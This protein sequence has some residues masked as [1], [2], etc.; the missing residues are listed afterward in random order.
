MFDFFFD[1]ADIDYIKTLWPKMPE[2]FSHDNIRGI[3]TNPNA[4]DKL[5]MTTLES[6]K[7]HLPKLCSLVSE[8]RGDNLGVV[9]VQMPS[10]SMS[11]SEAV[12]W[13]KYISTYSD[14]NT[15]LGLK[16][17]P[18]YNILSGAD[19][20]SEI[21]DLNVTGVSDCSTALSCF[22]FN[23]RYV[24]IIP[25]RMEEVGIDADAHLLFSQKRN[26]RETS[27]IITGSM[28]TVE[29]LKRAVAAGTVPTIGQRVWDILIDNDFDFGKLEYY[30]LNILDRFSPHISDKNTQ[31]SDSFFE[32]MDDFGKNVYSD[33]KEFA[34]SDCLR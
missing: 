27:E 22:N 26:N 24:S 14:G 12:S 11:L 17:P 33:W 28:R 21:M 19:E 34:G 7:S 13:A 6:W 30:N 25:G 18:Y 5:G 16:I 32:Q 9:Y 2:E 23:V 4:F 10:S 15:K 31:L 20:L 29:G 3:T 1:T 8:F